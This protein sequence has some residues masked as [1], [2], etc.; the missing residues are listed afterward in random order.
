MYFYAK[1]NINLKNQDY[2]YNLKKQLTHGSP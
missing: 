2:K 1:N